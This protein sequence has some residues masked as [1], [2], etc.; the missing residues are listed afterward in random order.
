[1]SAAFFDCPGGAFVIALIVNR[2]ENAEN[3]DAHLGS[4]F[5]KRVNQIVGIVPITHQILPAQKHLKLSIGHEFLQF[6]RPVPGVFA[7]EAMGYIEC[8]PTPD[9]HG[10]EATFI[11]FRGH[12]SHIISPHPGGNC[13]LMAVTKGGVTNF[14]RVLGFGPRLHLIGGQVSGRD[15]TFS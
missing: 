13:G 10:V 5:H 15:G 2:I 4:L 9:L 6:T 14:D 11:H 3:I 7:Q 8:R 1:M 12:Q